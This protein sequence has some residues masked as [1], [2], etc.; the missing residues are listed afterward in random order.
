MCGCAPHRGMRRFTRLTNAFSKKIE[1]HEA[2]VALHFQHYN[3]ARL[4]QTLRVTPAIEAAITNHVW[5]KRR[6]TTRQ[7]F[8]TILKFH[9]RNRQRARRQSAIRCSRRQAWIIWSPW[10][11]ATPAKTSGRP[12][13]PIDRLFIDADKEG[14]LDYFQQLSPLVRSGGL[15]LAHNVN[16]A[17]AYDRAVVANPALET[18]FYM[19]GGGLGV[20]LKK[21]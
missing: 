11:R 9:L 19:E 6:E 16:A 17:D 10:S 15:V 3:S 14:Y 12:K 13:E 5:S 7:A 4:H 1:N 21:R 2:S 20:T 18:L 8:M